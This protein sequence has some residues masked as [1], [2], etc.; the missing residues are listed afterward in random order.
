VSARPVTLVPGDGIGPEVVAAARRAVEATGVEID[1][2]EQVVGLPA[3]ELGEE[4]LSARVIESV[5]RNGVAL[6]GPVTTPADGR[7]P[8]VN[9]GLR[10]SLGLYAQVRPSRGNEIDVVVIREATEDLYAGIEFGGEAAQAL[11]AWLEPRGFHVERSAALAVKPVSEAATRRIFSFAFDWARR[12]GRRRVTSVHKATALPVTDGL[13][14]SVAHEVASENADLDFDERLVDEAAARLVTNPSELDVLVLQNFS[15]DVFSDLAA[16]LAG[17]V[18]LTPGAN[19]AAEVA[20]FEPG[21][22]SA[23]HRAG[24]NT[25]N[26]TGAILSGALLLSHLGF[27]DEARRLEQAVDAALRE[28]ALEAGTAEFT[29]AVVSRL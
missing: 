23:P 19:Y 16:A 11:G 20:V 24:K 18:G 27:A 12:H 6:K 8:S 21:H 3:T 5:R 4:P 28:T 25:A 13:W 29:D 10:R 26:P 2:D 22:G 14:A 15:G 17:G 9:L 7:F 1:W